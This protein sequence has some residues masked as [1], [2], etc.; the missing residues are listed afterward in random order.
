MIAFDGPPFLFQCSP[1][2][3][4]QC[5]FCECYTMGAT[6]GCG[7][8]WADFLYHW[9]TLRNS[10]K[11]ASTDIIK[12]H[13]QQWTSPKRV[14]SSSISHASCPYKPPGPELQHTTPPHHINLAG[15]KELISLSVYIM[16]C[17]CVDSTETT[18]STPPDLPLMW[19]VPC[20][21]APKALQMCGA[22]ALL[23]NGV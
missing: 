2:L 20:K 13:P 7:I 1:P 22:N 9:V 18:A 5:K 21:D 15:W 4:N 8:T 16:T 14:M 10:H 3:S 19:H 12:I 23:K 6:L 17:P 11:N